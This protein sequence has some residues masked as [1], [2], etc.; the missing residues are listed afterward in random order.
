MKVAHCSFTSPCLSKVTTFHKVFPATFYIC[1]LPSPV[2]HAS[3]LPH[4]LRNHCNNPA[5]YMS[6]RR[7]VMSEQQFISSDQTRFP[8][9]SAAHTQSASTTC[10]ISSAGI[11]IWWFAGTGTGTAT[12][13][14][15]ARRETVLSGQCPR[16]LKGN[17][18]TKHG[19]QWGRL[20]DQSDLCH[21]HAYCT[22]WSHINS[23]Q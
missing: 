22:A 2:H 6:C 15:G 11:L 16:L 10:S 8:V 9:C 14:W 13:G 20:S 23:C 1:V 7:H 17:A 21:V 4:P 18:D 19:K 3:S 12:W 5:M